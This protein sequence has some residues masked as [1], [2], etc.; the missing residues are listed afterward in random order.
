MSNVAVE[1]CGVWKKFRKGEMH[2]SLR[3]AVPALVK[4]ILGRAPRNNTLAK[5]E[6]W[7]LR[8]L[9]F[10]VRRGEAL[11]V[12]G[13]NGAG[14]S[15][16]LKILSKI[17]RPNAGSYR[18]N[19]R[20]RALIEVAAGFHSDLSGRENI[21]LNGA[22]LG[23]RR[24]EIDRR[25]D[26]IIDFSGIEQFIDTPVKHYSSGMQARLGF[27][28]AAHM[29]PEILL[30]DEVLSVGDVAFRAKCIAHL[31]RLIASDVSVIF[32][33]HSL[34]Q[35]Q[36]LCDRC[37]V[38]QSGRCIHVGDPETAIAK[39]HEAIAST[40]GNGSNGTHD[41]KGSGAVRFTEIRITGPKPEMRDLL[42]TGAPA[43]IQFL[44]DRRLS[45]VSC[46]FLIKDEQQNPVIRFNSSQPADIDQ[47]DCNHD[48]AAFEWRCDELPLLPGR[49]VIDAVLRT[50]DGFEADRME[51]ISSFR[52]E[53]SQFRGR[54]VVAAGH[55][56]NVTCPHSWRSA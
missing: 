53:G 2:D 36:R 32:I 21:Y 20:M 24:Y 31:E 9:S 22:I 1:V 45:G 34:E 39:Y 42:W 13:P 6:F 35:V 23:M 18:V 50:A 56:G 55:W 27:S 52:V 19:G 28:V 46:S 41:R 51:H 30:I 44:V 33:S 29:D 14:K 26:E 25:L 43:T 4:R 12:I 54:P 11:G 17:I 10:E 38:L 7:A 15:T 47:V 49:F 5:R 3:D 37:L 48:A 16:L 40:Y 8:D